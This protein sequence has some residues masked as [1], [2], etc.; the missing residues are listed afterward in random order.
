MYPLV[1]YGVLP[2]LPDKILRAIVHFDMGMV[3]L[4][5]TFILVRDLVFLP[6][7]AIKVDWAHW[8]FSKSGTFLMFIISFALL[9][10]GNWRAQR[11]PELVQVSIPIGNL[12]SSLENYKILQLSDL[13]TGPG[14][15]AAY[16]DNVIDMALR[17][18]ADIVVLTGDIADG[19]FEKY[20][21]SLKPLSK[22]TAKTQVLYVVGNHE[23]L[24]DSDQWLDY[25]RSLGIQVLLNDHW[26]MSSR[27]N[28][29]L[30]A[31]IIDPEVKEVDPTSGPDLQKALY[32]SP[33]A[34][35]KILLAHQPN[36]AEEASQYFDL[37]LSGHTHAGQFFPGNILIKLFQPFAKG[38]NKC[39]NMWVYTNSGTGY[40]GPP[41]RLGTTSE[42]T[43]LKLIKQ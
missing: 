25:F 15:N 5:I 14:I 38:L 32:G 29:I 16:V 22:L 12:P 34:D 41:F 31:G 1:W 20:K 6:L 42:I 26:V 23:Y 21:D 39:N 3:G 4:I 30:F 7:H 2:E 9:S 40:W 43:L 33:D 10:I 19:N 28:P 17:Q 24:K 36:I 18:E 37:Q 11:G 35:L 27:E 13:H 8:G